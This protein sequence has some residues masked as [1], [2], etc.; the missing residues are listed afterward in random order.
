MARGGFAGWEEDDAFDMVD[1]RP[2][3]HA[4]K[5]PLPWLRLV[6]LSSCTIAALAYFAQDRERTK[7][8]QSPKAVA[9]SVLIAPA[10]VW[11]TVSPSPAVYALEGNLGP[12]A[13]EARQH[14]S[15]ARE[16]TMV[17]GAFGN[18]RH[19]RITLVQGFDGPARTFFVDI[20]RRAAEAGLAVVR[21]GMSRM[22][23][24]KFGPVETAAV[25]LTGS[26]EQECQAF[27][28]SNGD[29]GFAF[30][31]WLCGFGTGADA[32]LA[33]FVDGIALAGGT[34]PSLKVLFGAAERNRQDACPSAARTASIVP[35][36]SQ[37][38]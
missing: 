16:D 19:A 24:T 22:V 23:A 10:P 15:G 33:C 9:R 27:R 25:T 38:P 34:N 11:R 30:Q 1:E 7:Q 26:S 6:L 17:L 31:G 13:L 12:V 8:A 32:Q 3:R 29:A 21:N 37:R 4:R 14:T 35:K 5:K 2:A 28:F 18:A 20:V 36:A